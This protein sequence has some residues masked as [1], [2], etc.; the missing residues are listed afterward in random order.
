MYSYVS[1][2]TL[3]GNIPPAVHFAEAYPCGSFGASRE[4]QSCSRIKRLVL[5]SAL[6]RVPPASLCL[7]ME[8]L[9]DMPEFGFSWQYQVSLESA[10][11]SF[12][13]IPFNTY[14]TRLNSIARVLDEFNGRGL[15]VVS[16]KFVGTRH[17]FTVTLNTSPIAVHQSQAIAPSRR[18]GFLS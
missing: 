18:A 14:R 4:I 9:P 11:S 16:H 2:N 6:S 3:L 17:N 5:A 8:Y 15:T 7:T 1:Q 10:Y 13:C 12:A